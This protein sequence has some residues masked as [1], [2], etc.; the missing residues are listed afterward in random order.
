MYVKSVAAAK[1]N[2]LLGRILT[3]SAKPEAM[4]AREDVDIS[5]GFRNGACSNTG[6]QQALVRGCVKMREREEEKVGKI[7][8]DSS[9]SKAKRVVLLSFGVPFLFLF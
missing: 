1:K 5:V 9:D 4:E 3:A 7:V 2:E 8:V 6:G